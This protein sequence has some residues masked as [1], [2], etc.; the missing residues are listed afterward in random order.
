MNL[1]DPSSC[2]A[3][4]DRVRVRG[5][6]WTIAALTPHPSG[7]ALHLR[8]DDAALT[9]LTPFDRPQRVRRSISPRR[10]HRRRWLHAV[11]RAACRARPFGSVAD[12]PAAAMAILPYQLEPTLAFVRHGA[13]RVLVADAVGLGK[14]IQSG[15]LIHTLR[16]ATPMARALIVTPAGLRAQWAG[17]LAARFGIEATVAEAGWL[18]ACD[19]ALPRGVPPWALPGVFV[20]SFDFLKRPEVLRP[21]E[22]V[23]WDLLVVD[24]AHNLTMASAR[25][26]AADAVARRAM[27]VLLLTATP[28]AGDTSEFE[29]LCSLGAVAGDPPIVMFRRSRRDAGVPGRRRSTILSVTPTP[30]ERRLHRLL[31]RYTTAVAREAR[32]RHDRR[33]RLLATVLKKR[34]LSSAASLAVSVQRRLDL[35]AGAPQASQLLLPLGDGELP[36]DLADDTALAGPGLADAGLEQRLLSSLARMARAAGPE[37]KPAFLLRLL[38]RAGEPAIVFTEFRDTLTRLREA[39]AD[40]GHQVTVLHGGQLAAERADAQR[41]FNTSGGVLLATDAAAEGLNLHERCRLVVHYELP[42]TPAR[43]EQRAGRVD[44]IG[45]PRTVHEVLLVAGHAGER[46]VLVPLARRA[47]RIRTALGPQAGAL[48]RLPESVVAEAVLDGATLDDEP[49]VEPGHPAVPLDLREEGTAEAGRLL[50]RRAWM[51]ASPA[52]HATAPDPA[53]VMASRRRRHATTVS[54]YALSLS[55]RGRLVHREL[56]AVRSTGVVDAHRVLNRLEPGIARI[57][58]QVGQLHGALARRA[59]A[60]A[61]ALPS[62]SRD[63]VQAGLFDQRVARSM[64]RRAAAAARLAEQL[65]LDD[66]DQEQDRD[67]PATLELVAVLQE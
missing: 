55:C 36:D 35:L 51:A 19:G 41:R 57:R 32:A 10:V 67:L 61:A 58:V 16:A 33:G 20:I 53:I 34:A 45:Q 37:S 50:E 27:R 66:E 54:I 39:L 15:L 22:D 59:R 21:L 63:L 65:G 4:G 60:L 29:A 47:A 56:V 46:L 3:D 7:A 49:F 18:R 40:A 2:W 62:A 6:L 31:D 23:T 48:D 13:T 1:A 44:R 38:R 12:V 5:R 26:A 28:H 64:Q 9:V 17:E 14:T 8:G 42:W 52:R 11:R 30:Q 43:L 25:R 24:E